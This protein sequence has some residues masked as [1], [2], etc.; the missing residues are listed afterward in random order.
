MSHSV[1]ETLGRSV[2]DHWPYLDMVVTHLC[3]ASTGRQRQE[4]QELK[5]PS[6]IQRVWGQ[7]GLHN[8]Q[9]ELPGHSGSHLQPQHLGDSLNCT[10]SHW[11]DDPP[12]PVSLWSAGITHPHTSVITHSCVCVYTCVFQ[13]GRIY[14]ILEKQKHLP[15]WEQCLGSDPG[16][17][18]SSIRLHSTRSCGLRP[19][20]NK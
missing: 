17:E 10:A 14:L 12:A 1:W 8:R 7:P 4:D 19:S 20:M 6:F 15:S 5:S 16:P 13:V 3:N 9:T 18:C 2:K 11:T